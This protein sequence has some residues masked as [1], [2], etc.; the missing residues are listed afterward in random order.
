MEAADARMALTVAVFKRF[1]VWKGTWQRDKGQSRAIKVKKLKDGARPKG[2]RC[3]SSQKRRR[4]QATC[5][6]RKTALANKE[7][8]NE[9][10]KVKD[11][12]R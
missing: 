1:V 11:L 4:Q 8:K 3:A 2:H 7:Q 6:A 5:V 12:L 9:L 10:M